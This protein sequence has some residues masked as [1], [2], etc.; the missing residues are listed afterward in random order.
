MSK[1]RTSWMNMFRSNEEELGPFEPSKVIRIRVQFSGTVQGVGFRY[2]TYHLA[3]R[4]GLL[5]WVKNLN[6]GDVLAEVQGEMDKVDYLVE[7]MRTLNRAHVSHVTVEHVDLDPTCHE[8][9]I[10]A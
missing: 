10:E 8:F 9:K 1:I 2:A 3:E 7:S 4:L 6:N 5:G